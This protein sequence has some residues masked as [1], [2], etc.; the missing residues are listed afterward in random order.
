MSSNINNEVTVLRI[1]LHDE[2][3]GYFA[4]FQATLDRLRS[5]NKDYSEDEILQIVDKA[6]EEVRG[7]KKAAHSTGRTIIF[8]NETP[9]RLGRKNYQHARRESRSEKS[10][11]PTPS[12]KTRMQ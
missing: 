1:T 12:T 8:T 6:V 7:G 9:V 10:D 4:G 2:L 11:G 5:R 3:V